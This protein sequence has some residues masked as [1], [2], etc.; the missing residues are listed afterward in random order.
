MIHT[1]REGINGQTSAGD[2]NTTGEGNKWAEK[3]EKGK[4]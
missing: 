1:E 4:E 2:N 3:K